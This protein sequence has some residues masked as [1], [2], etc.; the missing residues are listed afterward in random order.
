MEKLQH[1]SQAELQDL[2]DDADRVQSLALESDEVQNAQLE[3]EMALASNRSL[4][5]QNLELKPQLQQGRLRLVERYAELERVRATYQ[6][7]CAHRDQ[8]A[9]QVSPEGLFLQLQTEGASTETESEAL[10]DDFL[11]GSLSLESFLDRFLSLRSLAHRRRV[12]IEKLQELL[13]PKREGSSE[14]TG[15]GPGL[16]TSQPCAKP[17]GAPGV[18]SPWQ[19]P[20][21][22]HSDVAASNGSGSS[23]PSGP[24]AQAG[25]ALLYTP[26]PGAPPNSQVAVAPTGPTNPVAQ[27][28]SYPGQGPALPPFGLSSCPYPTHPAFPAS[29]APQFGQYGAPQPQYP[30]PY[31]FPRYDYPAGPSLAPPQPP[32]GRSGFV[33]QPYS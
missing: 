24:P 8:I 10:A 33:P 32:M 20:P 9:G 5:E 3:R 27:F 25:P 14:L 7:H 22:Q 2:L 26:Y 4:A 21:Q 16:M 11:S 28:P 13:R 18:P 1:L 6:Q 19:P 29:P 12:R 30:A 15:P 23:F 31:Q 17:E